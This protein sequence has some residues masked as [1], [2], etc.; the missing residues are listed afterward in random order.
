MIDNATEPSNTLY[1]RH[2]FPAEVISHAMWQYFRFPLIL[3][4]VQEFLAERG[5]EVLSI[6]SLN[7]L[8]NSG[9]RYLN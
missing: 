8:V 5:I 2:S 7:G 3:R 1:K 4:H 6:L 9:H